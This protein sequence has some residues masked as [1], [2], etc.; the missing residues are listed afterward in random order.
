MQVSPDQI[1]DEI[2]QLCVTT[3]PQFAQTT[4]R[5]LRLLLLRFRTQSQSLRYI[6][7]DRKHALSP[8]HAARPQ[9]RQCAEILPG[10]VGIERSPPRRQRQGEIYAGVPVRPRR[11]GPAENRQGTRRAA[12][13]THLQLGRGEIRRGPLFRPPRLRGR[14]HLRDLRPPEENGYYHQP[15]AARWPDGLRALAGP[16]FDR[17]FAKGRREAAGRA[18]GLDAEHRTLVSLVESLRPV[19]ED[20][21][22]RF[23]KEH[24]VVL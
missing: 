13:R 18:V 12:G 20:W 19:L 24:D 1:V 15:P 11:R 5:A 6:Q 22:R 2:A 3:C 17:A 4:A 14:R 7:G 9:P 21:F 23:S 16:A 10:C 8:H